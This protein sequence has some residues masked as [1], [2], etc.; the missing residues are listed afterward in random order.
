MALYFLEYDLRN[1]RNYQTLYDELADF[2]GVRILES[3]WCFKR[4]G[5]SAEGL[6]DHFRKFV[7]SDDGLMISEVNTWASLNVINTPNA[8]P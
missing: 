1:R 2:N 7:D 5:A 8:L 6:R 3:I 4:V